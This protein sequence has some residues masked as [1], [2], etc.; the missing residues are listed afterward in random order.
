MVDTIAAQQQTAD[1]ILRSCPGQAGFAGAAG[2]LA[3]WADV[4][5]HRRPSSERPRRKPDR[6]LHK[7]ATVDLFA[8]EILLVQGRCRRSPGG[9]VSRFLTY[10]AVPRP[11][12]RC[13]RSIAETPA[14]GK[15]RADGPAKWSP[16]G[17]GRNSASIR[18][19]ARRSCPRPWPRPTGGNPPAA[20]SIDTLRAEPERFRQAFGNGV[21]AVDELAHDVLVHFLM[22]DEPRSVRVSR[23]SFH[24]G[25]E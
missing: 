20:A 14:P 16:R 9:G 10:R 2:G 18:K 1:L 23:I 6:S 19:D 7:H 22:L 17:L 21:G 24:S 8:H 15:R 5:G 4:A 12:G 3:G 13:W 11:R 25:K